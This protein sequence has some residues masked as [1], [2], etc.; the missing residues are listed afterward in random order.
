MRQQLPRCRLLLL[1]LLQQHAGLLRHLL[2]HLPLP[3]GEG[4]GEGLLA[5]VADLTTIKAES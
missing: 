2:K 1:R 5:N 4:R 3:L